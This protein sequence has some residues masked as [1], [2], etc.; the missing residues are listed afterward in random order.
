[1]SSVPDIFLLAVPEDYPI[2]Q[3]LARRLRT[4]GYSVYLE[5][6]DADPDDLA[7][8]NRTSQALYG[9]S[10]MLAFVSGASALGESSDVFDEWW[11]SFQRNSGEIIACIAPK[12]PAGEKH[13]MSYDL[14]RLPR[15]DFRQPQGY[16]QLQAKLDAILKPSTTA[17]TA[18]PL[19]VIATTKPA[20]TAREQ[21]R[22]KPVEQS[23][24]PPII[25]VLISLMG[26]LAGLVVVLVLWLVLLRSTS[27][28][29]SDAILL[30][31][32]VI[33]IVV[34]G[35]LV[36][37][38]IRTQHQ[39]QAQF[40][41]PSDLYPPPATKETPPVQAA[42]PDV[43]IEVVESDF[44]EMVGQRW[45]VEDVE[46]DIGRAGRNTIH[47]PVRDVEKQHCTVYYDEA[48][49]Y[50]YLENKGT[51]RTV[52]LGDLLRAGEVRRLQNGD[53]IALGNSMVL[54][55]RIRKT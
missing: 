51:G 18:S 20:A 47:L 49:G 2:V 21:V 10:V 28:S 33:G 42:L 50:Y 6:P 53:L 41:Q 13:W 16:R 23:Q 44:S 39:Y 38:T 12:A 31:G 15:V 5:S 9:A 35:L 14:T 27:G 45:P 40:R 52:L 22:P 26:I 37:R 34:L 1:M 19:E 24:L 25:Q 29:R 46:V 48:D 3:K 54:Q 7:V 17:A 11:R 30:L 32:G 8:R 4:D 43:F 55:F 36:R